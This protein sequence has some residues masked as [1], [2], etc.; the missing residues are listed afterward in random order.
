M[1]FDL[2]NNPYTGSLTDEISILIKN[3]VNISFINYFS[4]KYTKKFNIK[5]K[6]IHQLEIGG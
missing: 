5:A 2:G 3:N 4:Y 6:K 1:N